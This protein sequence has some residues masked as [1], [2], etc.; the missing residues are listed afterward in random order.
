MRVR[1]PRGRE[2]SCEQVVLNESDD[3]VSRLPI[4]DSDVPRPSPA[5]FLVL[6]NSRTDF[7]V[8]AAEEK[9]MSLSRDVL[10]AVLAQDMAHMVRA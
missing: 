7:L 8:D 9:E 1:Q 6:C 4:V 2:R 5:F 10:Q 3:H